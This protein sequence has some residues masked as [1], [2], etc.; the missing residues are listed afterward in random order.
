MPSYIV[1]LHQSGGCDYTIE[2]G[3]KV[4]WL[5]ATT[6]EEAQTEVGTL[7]AEE[8]SGRELQVDTAMIYEVER[9]SSAD[10]KK[11]Y[12]DIAERQKAE[13]KLEADKKD[14]AQLAALKKRFPNG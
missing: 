7:L 2:C 12:R 13:R 6:M 4:R 1:E 3:T 11:I 5:E 9:S 8:Y 10:V 14:R